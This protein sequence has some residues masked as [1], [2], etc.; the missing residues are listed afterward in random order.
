MHADAGSGSPHGYFLADY[1]APIPQLRQACDKFFSLF[2]Q[3][4]K[5]TG[6]GQLFLLV[7]LSGCVFV[8]V[9]ILSAGGLAAGVEGPLLSRRFSH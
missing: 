8:L 4:A 7:I 9:V 2:L 1:Y 6:T 5:S 3:P